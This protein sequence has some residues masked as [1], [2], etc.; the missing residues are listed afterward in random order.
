MG[1][2]LRKNRK[3]LR[4][5]VKKARKG[6]RCGIPKRGFLQENGF[7]KRSNSFAGF[8]KRAIARQKALKAKRAAKKAAKKAVFKKTRARVIKLSKKN[9]KAALKLGK[10]FRRIR[11]SAKRAAAVRK[12]RRRLCYVAFWRKVRSTRKKVKP[13]KKNAKAAKI[14]KAN[15][16]RAMKKLARSMKKLSKKGWGRKVSRRRSARKPRRWG[17]IK[18]VGRKPR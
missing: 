18:K 6:H 1:W 17:K 8:V 9:R 3:A 2:G 7:F 10:Y 15:V 13:S 16:A 14:A 11:R 5:S 12:A 4:K